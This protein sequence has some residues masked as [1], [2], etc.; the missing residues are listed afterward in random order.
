M[1]RAP[2]VC[3]IVKCT[4]QILSLLLQKLLAVANSIHSAC[5]GRTGGC[6]GGG[7]AKETG[8]YSLKGVEL[9]QGTKVRLLSSLRR[10]ACEHRVPMS[11]AST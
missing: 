7:S 3:R 8:V 5:E 2:A 10:R 6:S 4:P 1:Y 9:P 11:C